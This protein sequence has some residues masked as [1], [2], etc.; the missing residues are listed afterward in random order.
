MIETEPK[1]TVKSLVD[2]LGLSGYYP[3]SWDG[4][5]GQTQ[6]KRMLKIAASSARKRNEPCE[7]VLLRGGTP[8][9]GKTTLGLLMSAELGK[10]LKL[11]SGKVTVQQ[12]RFL[13]SEMEDGDVLLWDEIHMA[14]TGGKSNAEWLLPFLEQG[15]I[16]GPNGPEDTPK[17]TVIGATT[18][19]GRLPEA[20]LTRFTKQP[21]LVE[22]TD[23]EAEF[24]S[25]NMAQTIFGLAL[26]WPS[27]E[28]HEQI[29]RAANNNP[30]MI[31]TIL[32]NLRDLA[33]AEDIE[34]E[35]G[36]YDLTEVFEWIGLTRDGLTK[37]AQEY[38]LALKQT[39][40]GK[41]GATAMKERLREPGGLAYTE[42]L[43]MDKGYIVLGT[44]GRNMTGAGIKR[45]RLLELEQEVA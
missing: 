37:Q 27:S 20:I 33:I 40:G 24:I 7:H 31:R 13:L 38:L 28:V 15:V 22:Y 5:I 17:I 45:V 10:H 21:D 41:A 34:P 23:I 30:R 18:D 3:D 12:A 11:V 32:V 9:I 16:V 19:A 14:V 29:A 6:A 39:F 36:A 44:G 26:P 2:D 35:D 25:T 43:L 8:G 4:F 1:V 42:R